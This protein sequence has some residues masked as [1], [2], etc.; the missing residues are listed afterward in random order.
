M[1]LYE[2]ADVEKSCCLPLLLRVCS[3]P[4]LEMQHLCLHALC[5]STAMS[6]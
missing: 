4:Y 3:E 1:N 2:I 5:G 6:S